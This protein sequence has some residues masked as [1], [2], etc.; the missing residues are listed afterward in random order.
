MFA[1]TAATVLTLATLVPGGVPK[2]LSFRTQIPPI[3]ADRWR[4]APP[5]IPAL[6]KITREDYLKYV[7]AKYKGIYKGVLDGAGKTDYSFQSG[8]ARMEAFR[9]HVTK[10]ERC[11]ANAM[12]LLEGAYRYYTEGPGGDQIRSGKSQLAT[13]HVLNAADAYRWVRESPSLKPADHETVRKWMLHVMK[14]Y[15]NWE[16]GAMNRSTGACVAAMVVNH[17]YPKDAGRRP[18]VKKV[19]DQ[20]WKFRDSF[21]NTEHY[22]CLWIKFVIA[23]IEHTGQ[24]HLWQDPAMKRFAERY[25]AQLTPVGGMSPYGDGTGFNCDPGR[26]IAIMEKWASVYKDGRF[27]WAA[28]RL[29]EYLIDHEQGYWQWG[30]PIYDIMNDLVAAYM[31]ADDS[32]PEV[33]PKMRSL[34]TQRKAWRYLPTHKRKG[35]KL[36]GELLDRDI[37]DKLIFRNGWQPGSTY[38][39]VEL[40]PPMGHGHADTGSINC[41]VSQGSV[42]LADT[43]YLVKDHE[44]HNAFLVMPDSRPQEWNWTRSVLNGGKV[45]ASVKDFHATAGLGYARVHITNYQNAPATL[46]RRVFFLGD[47]GLWVRDTITCNKPF[48]GRIGPAFQFTGVTDKRGLHWVNACQVA[49]PVAF[50]WDPKYMMQHTNRPWD[51]LVWC[52]QKPG[53]KLAVDD[54]TMDRNRYEVPRD[55]MNNFTHRA[56]HRKVVSLAAKKAQTFDTLLVP[57]RPT[58][59]ASRLAAGIKMLVDTAAS[60]VVQIEPKAGHKLYAGINDAGKALTAGPIAT[61]AKWFAVSVTPQGVAGYWLVEA[62]SLKLDGRDVFSATTRRTVEKT[63]P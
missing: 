47:A 15:W 40:C 35:R 22:N 14:N 37:P 25:L 53:A 13:D 32:I 29:M 60:A 7:K 18:Y 30:N 9:Y 58:G 38:A 10:D 52:A 41:F 59:D 8:Y 16:E 4:K 6:R 61:D 62:T 24:D 17:L 46:D 48:R 49:L 45:A 11:V 54:V 5:P 44:F 3:T 31:V 63:A 2:D 43:P 19:W 42:L 1:S 56:W 20:W 57:H 50:I 26:W 12:K 33:E 55:L 51:L 34:V 27:K 28:H 21:E 23:G 36:F 39:M